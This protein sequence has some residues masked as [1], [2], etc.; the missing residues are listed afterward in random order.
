MSSNTDADGA[1]GDIFENE[2]KT[3]MDS[4]KSWMLSTTALAIWKAE[5]F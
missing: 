2:R 5:A 4:R 3:I 1:R